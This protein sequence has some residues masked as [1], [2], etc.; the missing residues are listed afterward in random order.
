MPAVAA[1]WHFVAAETVRVLIAVFAV[2]ADL[3]ATVDIVAARAR[4][5]APT[6]GVA[7]APV[8]VFSGLLIMPVV[9]AET[10]RVVAELPPLAAELD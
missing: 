4:V 9:A 7:D 2:S 10:T 5:P 6:V 1:T 3:F 8:A